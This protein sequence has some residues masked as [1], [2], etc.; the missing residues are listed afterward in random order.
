M[1]A[2]GSQ[3]EF[4]LQ[5]PSCKLSKRAID[6]LPC[7]AERDTIWWDEDLKGFGL[8]VRK[9]DVIALLDAVRERGAL[10]MA[11]RVLAAVRKFFNWCVGRGG[12]EQSPCVNID[13]SPVE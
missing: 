10:V 1:L 4:R 5:M 3:H 9:R 13:E 2:L 8:E 6:A 7:P 11:N 12:L